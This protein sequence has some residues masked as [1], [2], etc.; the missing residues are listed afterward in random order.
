MSGRPLWHQNWEFRH[1]IGT[2]GIG[3]GFTAFVAAPAQHYFF[4]QLRETR[5]E[6]RVSA[7]VEYKKFPLGTLRLQAFNITNAEWQ[8]DRLFFRDTRDTGQLTR[9]I[10]RSRFLD[11]RFQVSLNGKF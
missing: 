2:S 7:F 8:R 10:E 3:W 11:T 9:I 6:T 1:D 5:E 4:N